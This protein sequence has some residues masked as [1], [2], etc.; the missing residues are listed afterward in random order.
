MV[1]G[2]MDKY[3]VPPSEKKNVKKMHSEFFGRRLWDFRVNFKVSNEKYLL[4]STAG[5]KFS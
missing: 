2:W 5:Q 4:E 3:M 1:D